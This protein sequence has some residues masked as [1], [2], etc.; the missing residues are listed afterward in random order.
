M[1]I[2]VNDEKLFLSMHC[3]VVFLWTFTRTI[4]SGWTKAKWFWL[5]LYVLSFRV[6]NSFDADEMAVDDRAI[7][8]IIP[9][10]VFGTALAASLL[11]DGW[12][13]SAM[14]S[15]VL[16][17]YILESS[18]IFTLVLFADIVHGANYSLLSTSIDPSLILFF[19]CL[20]K[21]GKIYA[22]YQEAVDALR[23][24]QLGRKQSQAILERVW[25]LWTFISVK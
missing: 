15:I 23:H 12:S 13:V 7:I 1:I 22:K 4:N 5:S 18:I 25:S 11:R 17:I 9:A 10:G 20:L 3:V 6:V 8:P 2:Y 19:I 24:E 21:L 14:S 16:V